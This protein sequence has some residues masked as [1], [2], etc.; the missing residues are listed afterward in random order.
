MAVWPLHYYCYPT[1]LMAA[2]VGLSV[3]SVL[4]LP[5][6]FFYVLGLLGLAYSASLP[7]LFQAYDYPFCVLARVVS[8]CVSCVVH[9]AVMVVC[10]CVR[11]CR[12][13]P[14]LLLLSMSHLGIIYAYQFR[15]IR[16]HTPTHL[17]N[18]LGTVRLMLFV[19][20]II[21]IIV[22]TPDCGVI[23]RSV[24]LGTAHEL[25]RPRNVALA[26]RGRL[27]RPHRSLFLGIYNPPSFA[28]VNVH[29]I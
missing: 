9:R 21:I 24:P 20:I 3:P 22:H 14:A 18:L 12:L 29:S 23:S 13:W 6:L 11:W 17:T 2:V 15:Y 19:F 28:V 4:G 5:Y 16:D 10:A 1:F 26:S 8:S 7:R 27:G 25:E